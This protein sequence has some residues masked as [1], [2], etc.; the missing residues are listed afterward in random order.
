MTNHNQDFM[1]AI[2]ILSFVIGIENY[3]EN[4]SQS[5][6]DDIMQ[7]IDEKTSGILEAIKT[8]LENQNKMLRQML[9]ILKG[10]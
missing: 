8:E 1:D 9:E 7:A 5:D 4:L 10:E 2:A 6:K 3:E